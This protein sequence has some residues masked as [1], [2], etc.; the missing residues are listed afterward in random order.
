MGIGFDKNES[1]CGVKEVFERQIKGKR[2][3]KQGKRQRKEWDTSTST[4]A[5]KE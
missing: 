3:G 4:S 2:Q 1:T 5:K